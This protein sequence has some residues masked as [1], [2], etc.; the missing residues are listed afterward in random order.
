MTPLRI[1]A[2]NHDD[3]ECLLL[4]CRLWLHPDSLHGSGVRRYVR[5]LRRPHVPVR[6]EVA[7]LPVCHLRA[8]CDVRGCRRSLRAEGVRTVYRPLT[9]VLLWLLVVFAVGC[10]NE[11]ENQDV[12][13]DP[14][15]TTTVI[16]PALTPAPAPAPSEAVTTTTSEPP[17]GSTEA[18]STETVPL[19]EESAVLAAGDEGLILST[20]E[21]GWVILDTPEPVRLAYPDHRGG[22]IYQLDAPHPTPILAFTPGSVGPTVLV[23]DDSETDPWLHSVSLID[24]TPTLIYVSSYWICDVTNDCLSQAPAHDLVFMDLD[25]G[26]I[27]NLGMVAS[28]DD[29]IRSTSFGGGLLAH[30]WTSELDY[31]YVVFRN[32]GSDRVPHPSLC[33]IEFDSNDSVV[34][35]CLHIVLSPDGTSLA[36]LGDPCFMPPWSTLSAETCPPEVRIYDVATGE[37]TATVA[38][39]SAPDSPV[40]LDADAS[41]VVATTGAGV[42]TIGYD[43]TVIDA[44]EFTP[45][46]AGPGVIWAGPLPQPTGAFGG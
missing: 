43:G 31:P 36:T 30:M 29:W 33:E 26:V 20:I 6:A 11:A 44:I 15:T 16:S 38:L 2:W 25:T 39:T 24:D 22:I 19:R 18:M 21:G 40:W 14:T 45:N 37:E 34:Y 3:N 12:E 42:W 5:W 1:T 32:L 7:L 35:L 28:W 4:D 41:H 17:V 23:P 13:S 8:Y 46:R 9:L 10:V 27:D